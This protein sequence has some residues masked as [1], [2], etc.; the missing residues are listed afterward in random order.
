[1]RIFKSLKQECLDNKALLVAFEGRCLTSL[2]YGHQQQNFI[3]RFVSKNSVDGL[4]VT[5]AAAPDEYPTDLYQ[6]HFLTP[7]DNNVVN[8]YFDRNLCHTIRLRSENGSAELAEHLISAH[9]YKKF[10]LMR[11]PLN[12]DEATRRFEA[13]KQVLQK[14]NLLEQAQ[15]YQLS[16]NSTEAISV[17]KQIFAQDCLPDAII[18]PNDESAIAV[19]D[20]INN[21]KPELVG[22]IAV[23]GFDNST[24][25]KL[26]SPQLTTVEH[27]HEKMSADAVRLL[28]EGDPN[29]PQLIL[30]DTPL[31][32]RQSCGCHYQSK[33]E[34]SSQKLFTEDFNLYDNTQSLS[35]QD[36]FAKLTTAL[37]FRGISGCYI[38]CYL[39]DAFEVTETTEP[40]QYSEL[41]YCFHKGQRKEFESR[42]MF[43]TLELLPSEQFSSDDFSCLV[44]RNLFYASSHFGFVVFDMEQGRLQDLQEI[45]VNIATT[46]NTIRILEKMQ[47]MAHKNEYLLD[48]LQQKNAQLATHNKSLQR[49]S[50]IDDMTQVHNRRGF[51]QNFDYLFKHS[52]AKQFTFFYADLDNLKSINDNLSHSAGDSAIKLAADSLK[53]VFR[54]ADIVARMGGDEFVIA[55]DIDAFT[56]QN[57][58]NRLQQKVEAIN[59]QQ[60]LA[61]HF[62]ISIGYYSFARDD[63][64]DIDYAI[65]R[66]DEVLYDNKRRRKAKAS[67]RSN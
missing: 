35:Y 40:P 21:F 59:Q 56:A 34:S 50:T 25:A 32:Y 7:L 33:V 14:H 38:S 54:D 36:F 66:A 43:P 17:A 28:K 58:I 46:L 10:A 49:I 62:G 15:I 11:G 47:K 48:V 1:M 29:K 57:I 61:F 65:K 45:S 27:P 51:Y 44:V 5:T 6:K 12:S 8:Y 63:F 13:S 55:A 37:Q 2:S 26:V 39:D 31:I 64:V 9:G 52:D 42:C 16:W 3:Y 24:N 23:V 19:L 53:Q 30:H 18:F 4:I 60:N 22:K 20:Y 41:I 67:N